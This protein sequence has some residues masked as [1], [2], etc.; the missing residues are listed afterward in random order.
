MSEREKG[1]V[2]G[3]IHPFPL[4]DT[5]KFL[6]KK[7][8]SHSETTHPSFQS[9]PLKDPE[10]VEY[11]PNTPP[12]FPSS[13]LASPHAPLWKRLLH[14]YDPAFLIV[15][16]WA[17]ISLLV[18][19]CASVVFGIFYS[20]VTYKKKSTSSS[21]VL[22]GIVCESP[23]GSILGVVYSDVFGYSN[24]KD[25]YTSREYASIPVR[26]ASGMGVITQEYGNEKWKQT[27]VETK[28]EVLNVVTGLKW[29][30]VEFAR[31]FW[32]LHG[33]S[34]GG[35]LRTTDSDHRS[36]VLSDALNSPPAIFGSVD[37]AADIWWQL[38]SVQLVQNSSITIPLKKYPNG[39]SV[40]QGGSI[41]RAKD[42]LIY[43]RRE[44]NFPYGHVAVIVEVVLHTTMTKKR[45]A[46]PSPS[47]LGV[48]PQWYGVVRVA[49]Q[50]WISEMWTASPYHNY[51]R[52]LPL[53]YFAANSSY[54]LEDPDGIILGWMRY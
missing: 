49:E 10:A 2:E 31:R 22:D 30:C 19:F 36:A 46:P 20:G 5:P 39:W 4:E 14:R 21:E 26:I 27:C 12:A 25:T 23:F 50:N 24:C 53:Y 32:V 16:K 13:I 18:L 48:T 40:L 29:Q 11:P 37:G 45:T 44:G 8:H 6:P 17:L 35:G 38:E 41:P 1:D 3:T 42:L 7:T 28:E 51:T 43:E 34:G 15:A 9:F 33:S 47:S 52:E 54:T